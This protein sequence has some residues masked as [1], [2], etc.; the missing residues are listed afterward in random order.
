MIRMK[1]VLS[2]EIDGNKISDETVELC[3]PGSMC[4]CS[5]EKDSER[6]LTDFMAQATDMLVP[7]T[8][9]DVASACNADT[10]GDGNGTG[11]S[12]SK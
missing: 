3:I 11:E 1:A 12:G 5:D 8:V 9:E 10:D 7:A 6:I 4:K 2:V